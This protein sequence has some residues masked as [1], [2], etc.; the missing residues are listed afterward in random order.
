M[1]YN[2][3][4]R[5]AICRV[6]RKGPNFILFVWYTFI[7][8][9]VYL[10]CILMSCHPD[11]SVEIL[12]G[13]PLELYCS[14]NSSF[15]RP[16]FLQGSTKLNNTIKVNDTTIK[17]YIEKPEKS[18]VTY[19]CQYGVKKC[20]IRVLVDSPPMNVT[21]FDC[22]SNNL[23]NLNCS[24]TAP[25]KIALINYTLKVLINKDYMVPCTVRVIDI[26]KHYCVWENT[27]NDNYT[28]Y[29]ELE[30]TFH[31]ELTA[32]N[33]FGTKV[34][35]FTIDHYAVVKP[36][37]P[38]Y[39]KVI[40]KKSHS[41]QLQ[42]E[43]P[44]IIAHLLKCGV[45]HKIEYQIAKIDGNFSVNASGL[46][47][48]NTTYKFW[49][50]NL[51]Y[52]HMHYEVMIYIRSKRA[53][54]EEFWSNYNF[55]FFLTASER[56]RRPP[57]MIAG[58]FSETS[59]DSMIGSF[60][61][62]KIIVYWEQLKEYEEAGDNFTY[63]V[64][65][66]GDNKTEVKYP[67][68]TLSLSYIMLENVPKKPM[69]ISVQ[70]SNVNGSSINSSHLYIPAE[71][72]SKL[73]VSR[74][75]Q[76]AYDEGIYRLSWVINENATKVDNYTLLWCQHNITNICSGR[77]GFKVLD[78]GIN[79]YTITNLTTEYRYQFAI[80]ANKGV[81]TSGI[82]W[83]SCDISK[84][85]LEVYSFPV[86]ILTEETGK[87]YVVISWSFTCEINQEPNPTV[88]GYNITYCVGVK[89]NDECDLAY[90]SSSIIITDL[91]EMKAKITGLRPYKTYLFRISLVT[92]YGIMRLPSV[93][94]VTT[95]E[96]TPTPPRNVSIVDI[97]NNSVTL[98][99]DPPDPR[100]GII[101]KYNI[102][103]NGKEQQQIINV[104]NDSDTKRRQVLLSSLNP[105]TNYSCNVMACNNKNCSLPAPKN[106][107]LVLT[108]IG[109]P[110]QIKSPI[111][112]HSKPDYIA[113]QPPQISGGNIDYYEIRRIVDG[114][115]ERIE[116][117]E[118]LTF[119]LTL[120]FNVQDNETFQIRAVNLD[121]QTQF[122]GEWSL[123]LTN[124]CTINDNTTVVVV[125][126]I[127]FALISIGYS[128]LKLYQ[129]YRNMDIKPVLP[130]GLIVPELEK[131]DFGWNASTKDNNKMT[132]DE[133]LP[134]TNT[135]TLVASP[136]VKQKE[137]SY[138][139]SS[140]HTNSTTVS[141]TSHGPINRHPSTS[142]ED[143]NP[144]LDVEPPKITD[145]AIDDNEYDFD[146][147]DEKIY[148]DSF[149]ERPFVPNPTPVVN[150]TTGYVQ[151]VP[152]PLKHPTP[153][154][155]ME[156]SSSSYVKAGLSP[157]IFT[158][159]V[160][161]PI[162][163]NHPPTSSGYVLHEDTLAN[164][165]IIPKLGPPSLTFGP[166]SLPTMPNLPQ[167]TNQN[168]S[169]YIQLQS[170]DALSSLKPSECNIV[171]SMKPT[172]PDISPSDAIINKHLSNVLSCGQ[173]TDDPPVLDPTMSP[174]AYCRFSWSTDPANDNLQTFYSQTNNSYNK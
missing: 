115:N 100:N 5:T 28:I 121:K 58:A 146:Y 163:K 143:S 153:K 52:A 129:K 167:P 117:S 54:K 24:W 110:S 59:Y 113:W 122:P 130:E 171:P 69:E 87:T 173:V 38:K 21:D 174:D 6:S 53:F 41:V 43:I 29:R 82:V 126:M 86:K 63:K 92:I 10:P 32:N 26:Y 70:S 15:Q 119:N 50:K 139:G 80:S 116:K 135:K 160:V 102:F 154:L 39:V 42:W 142:D 45:E 88:K 95:T 2:Q 20:F 49:L 51:P 22:I 141:D 66:T 9:L 91:K 111:T 68:K 112:L 67:N 19:A 61:E 3:H 76:I 44:N 47:I 30:D 118:N 101:V 89:T 151:S 34:Q 149:N 25:I 131:Y 152:A 78:G 77:L 144:S 8:T 150:A 90:N 16:E 147:S 103:C 155:P 23:E 99:F 57:E 36:N 132:S 145:F 14:S 55:T 168:P 12:Y 75:T 157:P 127:G 85:T 107:I 7:I 162:V 35:Y 96:D 37:P 98:A 33:K 159:G 93:G 128:I 83:A 71:T 170:L 158:T 18:S 109:A 108:R 138:C 94:R 161:P 65:V 64:N 104:E 1:A 17:L 124:T 11:G 4:N 114:K 27:E 140:E 148:R 106:G 166:D 74:F 84:D 60:S 31:F 133:T 169:S 48:N 123:P 79:N 125:I 120:C 13:Q 72:D 73:R 81:S 165:M 136:E 164:S 156:P 62:R 105:Y 172:T 46:P 56:P 40:T 134:L 137:S 97:Q